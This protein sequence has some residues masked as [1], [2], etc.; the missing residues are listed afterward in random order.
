MQHSLPLNVHMRENEFQFTPS[1]Q[2]SN[3]AQYHGQS[4][5]LTAYVSLLSGR[6]RTTILFTQRALH[7][8]KSPSQATTPNCFCFHCVIHASLISV[9][10]PLKHFN[11]VMYEGCGVDCRQAFHTVLHHFY[12]FVSSSIVNIWDPLLS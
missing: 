8:S 9:G 5:E 1:T 7:M 2:R 11:F 10:N 4:L 3:I 6:G 12:Y